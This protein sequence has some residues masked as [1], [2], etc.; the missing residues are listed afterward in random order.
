MR[1]SMEACYIIYMIQRKIGTDVKNN[2]NY[3]NGNFSLRPSNTKKY[4]VQLLVS[5]KNYASLIEMDS[6]QSE[7]MQQEHDLIRDY[8]QGAE[9]TFTA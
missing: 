1:E 5:K 9:F 6:F 2:V 3:H 7:V 4:T 8:F